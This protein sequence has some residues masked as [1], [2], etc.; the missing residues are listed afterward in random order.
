[1]FLIEAMPESLAKDQLPSKT[2]IK[3]TKAYYSERA[4]H[5][6]ESLRHYLSF[7]DIPRKSQETFDALAI[8]CKKVALFRS[9]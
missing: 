1:V 8:V 6:H 7:L 4:F 2:S 9:H 5:V 3:L